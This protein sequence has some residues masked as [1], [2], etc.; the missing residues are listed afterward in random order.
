MLFLHTREQFLRFCLL[1]RFRFLSVC[2][3][4]FRLL[5]VL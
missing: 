3:F 1:V 4:R 5:C 2:L